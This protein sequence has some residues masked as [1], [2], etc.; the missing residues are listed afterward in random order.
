MQRYRLFLDYVV[1]EGATLL[2]FV[3]VVLHELDDDGEEGRSRQVVSG[4]SG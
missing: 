2:V 1:L 3:Q 4:L